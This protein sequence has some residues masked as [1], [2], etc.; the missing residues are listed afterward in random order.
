M[1]EWKKGYESDDTLQYES[2]GTAVAG[3]EG[4]IEEEDA[5]AEG[6]ILFARG[7]SVCH[8]SAYT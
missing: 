5:Q 3:E 2:E 1:G 7:Y 4:E 8:S 6:S